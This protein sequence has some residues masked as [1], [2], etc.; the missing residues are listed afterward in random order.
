MRTT[1]NDL[2]ERLRAG[3]GGIV[4]PVCDE[5]ANEIDDWQALCE[6]LMGRAMHIDH[7][8]LVEFQRLAHTAESGNEESK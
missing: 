7:Q 4:P 2:T 1:M 8:E 5:A 6:T 3:F